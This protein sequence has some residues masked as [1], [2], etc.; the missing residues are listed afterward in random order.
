MTGAT[1]ATGGEGQHPDLL[2]RTERGGEMV[3]G[4]QQLP[5]SLHICPLVTPVVQQ[6]PFAI[7]VASWGAGLTSWTCEFNLWAAR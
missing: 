3:R 7:T 5:L 2:K 1:A 6:N 4:H